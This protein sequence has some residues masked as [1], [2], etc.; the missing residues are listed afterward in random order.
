[1]IAA[2][3]FWA[4]N[5]QSSELLRGKARL[6]ESVELDREIACHVEDGETLIELA[7]EG[8]SVDV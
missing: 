5:D 1:M 2:P 4:A 7:G 8:E 6:G 3:D